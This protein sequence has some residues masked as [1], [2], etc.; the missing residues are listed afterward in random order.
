MKIITDPN[1]VDKKK[2]SEFVYSHPNGNIFQTPEMYDVYKKTKNYE[3]IFVSIIDNNRVEALLLAAIQKENY[4]IFSFLT[5]RSIIFGGPLIGSKET[6]LLDLLLNEYSKLI[7]YKAI[8]T[9]IRN[10]WD[11]KREECIFNKY[12]FKLDDHLNIINDLS[13]SI[14]KQWINLSKGR[15]K[16]IKKAKSYG[17]IFEEVNMKLALPQFF[18]LLSNLYLRIKLPIPTI[19][20]F[21]NLIV[22]LE[23]KGQIIFF[24]LRNEDEVL[25]SFLGLLYKKTIYG[26]YIGHLDDSNIK[27]NKAMDLF[28][29][30][31]LQWGSINGFDRFDW[32]GAGKPDKD[33]G[34][35]DFK[36]QYGGELFNFGRFEKAHNPLLYNIGTIGL[37][38]WQKLK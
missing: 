7:K 3:P 25:I 9:Q 6:F 24:N 8:Y 19:S 5:A 26:Y 18:K 29:W 17:F 1:Q 22:A 30:E 12:G 35:R 32:M 21:E 36:L 34:V 27:S 37:F 20:Y 23:E 16:G 33:Y 31:L 2:W 4:G 13:I 28:F 10:F 14:E 38:I 15:R 11:F